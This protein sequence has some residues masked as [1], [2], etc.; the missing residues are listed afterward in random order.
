MADIMMPPHPM[1]VLHMIPF[2]VLTFKWS[3]SLVYHDLVTPIADS[4]LMTDGDVQAIVHDLEP[5]YTGSKVGL[6]GTR[7]LQVAGGHQWPNIT[8]MLVASSHGF[9]SYNDLVIP[10][11]GMSVTVA[12]SSVIHECV[13][14][15]LGLTLHSCWIL[16]GYLMIDLEL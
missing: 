15:T 2:T 14:T 6:T 4:M 16:G 7:M 12:D 9:V 13:Y 1:V 8:E 5:L 10:M 11:T 3:A